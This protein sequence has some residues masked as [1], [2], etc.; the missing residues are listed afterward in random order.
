M[1]KMVMKKMITASVCDEMTVIN[2]DDQHVDKVLQEVDSR[3]NVKHNEM[4][5]CLLS[6]RKKTD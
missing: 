5:S 4:S 3:D 6:K 1:M 2:T